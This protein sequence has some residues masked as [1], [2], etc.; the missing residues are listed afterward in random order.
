M[1]ENLTIQLQRR[2]P[3][4]SRPGRALT[5]ENIQE[6]LARNPHALLEA[7]VNVKSSK[8]LIDQ[9]SGSARPAKVA[10]V[11]S[12]ARSVR[13]IMHDELIEILRP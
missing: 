5:E 11:S 10:G 8:Q 2:L 12:P 6:P 4:P 7:D 1:V 13:Q 9:F 3:K